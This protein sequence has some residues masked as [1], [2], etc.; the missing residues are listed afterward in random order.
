[1]DVLSIYCLI[2]SFICLR[3]QSN[4]AVIFQMFEDVQYLSMIASVLF[5]CCA[6]DGCRSN[7]MAALSR[8]TPVTCPFGQVIQGRPSF[9]ARD[10]LGALVFMAGLSESSRARPEVGRGLSRE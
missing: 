7:Y 5:A 2:Y 9:R 6:R 10:L 4:N 8:H 1:M 3:R